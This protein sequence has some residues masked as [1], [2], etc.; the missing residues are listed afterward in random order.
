[1]YD[2]LSSISEK[3]LNVLKAFWQSTGPMQVRDLVI[4]CNRPKKCSDGYIHTLVNILLEKKLVRI[5]GYEKDGNTKSRLLEAT[6]SMEQYAAWSLKESLMVSPRYKL[7]NIIELLLN[8]KEVE[9]GE[10]INDIERLV[11][12]YGESEE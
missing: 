12:E 10:I 9:S 3:E 2:Q 5:V 6:I 11:W 8:D 1:M 4:L 7:S